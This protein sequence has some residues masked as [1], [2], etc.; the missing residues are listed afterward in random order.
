[1]E[2][3]PDYAPTLNRPKFCDHAIRPD[4]TRGQ[5][6][7]ENKSRHD[8]VPPDA[9]GLIVDVFTYGA[10]KYAPRNW[11]KGIG[12]GRLF[13][14][15][16]RHLWAF[17]R[18]EEKDEDSGLPHLAHA[19]CTIMML[20]AHTQRQELLRFDERPSRRGEDV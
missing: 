4:E 12:Y 18:G 20:L 14:A 8:L 16:L 3:S 11:E 1:M 13:S 17:W 7:D 5:K 19:G 9:Y 10:R 2:S 15:I 6:F